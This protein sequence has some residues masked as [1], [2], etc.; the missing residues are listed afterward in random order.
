[1]DE[2]RIISVLTLSAI[3]LGS[4]AAAELVWKGSAPDEPNRWIEPH[5]WMGGAI[6]SEHDVV[7][8]KGDAGK[9]AQPA[10]QESGT[11]LGKTVEFQTAGWTLSL[12][13]GKSYAYIGNGDGSTLISSQGNGVNTIIALEP[14]IDNRPLQSLILREGTIDVGLGNT[15]IIDAKTSGA[16]YCKLGPGALWLTRE[17]ERTNDTVIEGGLLVIGNTHGS[18]TGSGVLRVRSGVLCGDGMIAGTVESDAAATIA[19]GLPDQIGTLTVQGLLDVNGTLEMQIAKNGKTLTGDRI[20][21][22]G[23]MKCQGGALKVSAAGDGIERGDSWKLFSARK[24]SGALT[25]DLPALKKEFLWDTSSVLKDGL[26]RVIDN[27]ATVFSELKIHD[28]KGNPWRT[29]REDW[30]HARQLVAKDP[31]WKEWVDEKRAEVDAWIKK[32]P[33]DRTNWICGR[34]GDGISKIDGSKIKFTNDI[35]GEDVDYFESSLGNREPVSPKL[36][37]A[38]VA[39]YRRTHVRKIAEAARLWRLTGE[40]KYGKWAED[41]IQF[42]AD[43]YLKW[44]ISDHIDPVTQK[45]GGT[46]IFCTGL[47]TGMQ[48]FHFMDAVRALG[49]RVAPGKRR[50][51]LDHLFI[52]DARVLE[53]HFGSQE[54][55]NISLWQWEGVAVVGLMANDEDMWR[56]ALARVRERL[57]IGITS[58]YVWNEQTFGY[59]GYVVGA[60]RCLFIAADLSGKGDELA[61]EKNCVGNMMLAPM[62]LGFP[63]NALPIVGDCGVRPI[64]VP[65]YEMLGAAGRFFPTSAG[66]EQAKKI[67]SWDSLLDPLPLPPEGVLRMPEVRSKNFEGLRMAILKSDPWQV[68]LLYGQLVAAHAQDEVLNFS[69]YYGKTCLVRD[70]ATVRYGSPFHGNYFTRASAHSVPLINSLGQQVRPLN[71]G[72]LD[73]FSVNP[74]LMTAS[75]PEYRRDAGVVRTFKIENNELVDTVTVTATLPGSDIGLILHLQG[76]VAMTPAFAVDPDF[77]KGRPAP[78][79][80]SYWEDVKRAAF[81]DEAEFKVN[82]NGLWMRVIVTVPG[83]FTVWHALSPDTP[84]PAKRDTLFFEVKDRKTVAFTSRFSPEGSPAT[85]VL[86]QN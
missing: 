13:R 54:F 19:P 25:F 75:Q 55:H 28:A 20:Q 4:A 41:Q 85:G 17:S 81:N 12:A 10:V 42:Y 26:I 64:T 15:L 51:W 72:T 71:S 27:P 48:L 3:G 29:A 74:P 7:Q 59:N 39:E 82:Y 77:L 67:K 2:K 52:P 50:Y 43:N 83:N 14:M 58:D 63:D 5:N 16:E 46:R 36:M 56:R 69:A 38:W 30:E 57:A 32:F 62:Y 35:P 21:A 60:A 49:V 6:P 66:L 47:E 24:F 45:A 22:L 34:L 53:N 70:A 31:E 44:P 40:E 37:G 65:Q 61:F 78:T 80:F 84:L 11:C 33:Y 73:V 76:Q 18:A 23:E 9:T 68:F 86:Q 1:M 79:A 8:F